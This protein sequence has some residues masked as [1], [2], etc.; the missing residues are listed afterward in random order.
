MRCK[1]RAQLGYNA[2]PAADSPDLTQP[3]NWKM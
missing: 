1:N 3:T 2:Q